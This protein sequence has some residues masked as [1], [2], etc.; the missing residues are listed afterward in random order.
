MQSPHSL[1]QKL[2]LLTAESTQHSDSLQIIPGRKMD[3]C[4]YCKTFNLAAVK[5][6]DCMRKITLEPFMLTTF[7]YQQTKQL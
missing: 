5:I 2:V 6:D 1:F 7:T 3:V 4:N